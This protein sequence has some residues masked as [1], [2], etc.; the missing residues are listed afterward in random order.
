MNFLEKYGI[1]IEDENL[2]L[3]ALTH[4]SY[5]YENHVKDYERLEFLG[6]AILQF[7]MSEYYYKNT[8]LKEG[9]MSKHRAGYV[10]EE[11]LAY[12]VK[13]VGY[14]KYIRVGNGLIGKLNNTI[15]ADTF[16]AVLAVIYLECGMEVCKKY[17]YEVVIP[18]VEEKKNCF[19]DYK[20]KLQEL[21]QTD[22]KSID[23]ILVEMIG[24][25]P[26]EEF[27]VNAVVGGIVLGTGIGRNKKE[28]EQK[29]A[30]EAIK[31]CA[32]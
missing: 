4:S 26:N 17:V 6:D 9:E 28:A 31:K 22:K 7:I 16:E 24:D 11:A 18:C 12:Y 13:K 19:E 3:T 21:V 32:R 14:D 2:L 29:A 10:C 15:I 20:T 23:Y 1:K 5:A 30:K 25:A 27:K 8:T